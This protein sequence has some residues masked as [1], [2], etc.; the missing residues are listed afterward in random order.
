[1]EIKDQ[2]IENPTK[3][4]SKIKPKHTQKIDRAKENENLGYG[5]STK[6]KKMKAEKE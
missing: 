6:R 3:T 4:W 2:W 5:N 1:M